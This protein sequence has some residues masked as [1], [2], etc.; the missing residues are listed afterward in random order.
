VLKR[1]AGRLAP[2]TSD[3]VNGTN[4]MHSG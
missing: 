4:R 2:R 1:R 3:Q